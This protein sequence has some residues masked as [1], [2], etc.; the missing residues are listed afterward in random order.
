MLCVLMQCTLRLS[1]VVPSAQSHQVQP[2]AKAAAAAP[3]PAS[4]ARAQSS[5]LLDT[6]LPV[7]PMAEPLGTF[8]QAPQVA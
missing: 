1:T 8:C 2:G 4:A 3:A 7:E 6:L 5:A